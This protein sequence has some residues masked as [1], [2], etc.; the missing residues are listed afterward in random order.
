MP[1]MPSSGLT[2]RGA[3]WICT[4]AVPSG[5][6]APDLGDDIRDDDTESGKTIA[7]VADDPEQ[8]SGCVDGDCA[9]HSEVAF[10]GVLHLVPHTCIS[11]AP[12]M[13]P[14][15]IQEVFSDHYI[16]AAQVACHK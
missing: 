1:G 14:V 15:H 5:R 3:A 6:D 16:L 7:M 10:H 11:Y 13:S 8:S 2:L 12:H 4:D 9:Q